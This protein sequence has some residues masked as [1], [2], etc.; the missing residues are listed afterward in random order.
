MNLGTPSLWDGGHRNVQLPNIFG[1]GLILPLC[2][3][4]TP[5]APDFIDIRGRGGA[6]RQGLPTVESR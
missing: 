6:G 3:P 2:H 5:H 4:L 1:I